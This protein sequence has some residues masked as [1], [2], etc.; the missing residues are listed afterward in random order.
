MLFSGAGCF[1]PLSLGGGGMFTPLF[2]LSRRRANLL[3]PLPVVRGGEV[4]GCFRG[5]GC[6]PPFCLAAG[7]FGVVFKG[8]VFAAFLLGGEGMFGVPPLPFW[9]MKMFFC[10]WER[11]VGRKEFLSGKRTAVIE[12]DLTKIKRLLQASTPRPDEGGAGKI[13]LAPTREARESGKLRHL[14]PQSRCRLSAE[15]RDSSLR[16]APTIWNFTN[17]GSIYSPSRRSRRKGSQKRF[18]GRG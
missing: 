1:P 15:R 14:L 3:F 9:G 2:S 4:W 13:C 8:R 10:L 7:K 11:K 16:K 12:S 18:V 5:A 17:S 6:P